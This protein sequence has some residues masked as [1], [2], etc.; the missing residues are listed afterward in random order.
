MNLN[1]INILANKLMNNSTTRK[2]TYSG[3]D[4]V[5]EKWEKKK[6]KKKKL[7]RLQSKSK[8]KTQIIN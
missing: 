3:K 5:A 4:N 7:L 1:T 6:K 8:G 2:I